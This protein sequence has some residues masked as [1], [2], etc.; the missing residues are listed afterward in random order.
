MQALKTFTKSKVVLHTFIQLNLPRLFSSKMDGSCSQQDVNAKPKQSQQLELVENQLLKQHCK[1]VEQPSE[2][3]ANESSTRRQNE[4]SIPIEFKLQIAIEALSQLTNT[5]ETRK[6]AA[7]KLICTLKCMLQEVDLRISD[8]QRSAHDFHKEVVEGGKCTTNTERYKAEKFIRYM[9]QTLLEQESTLDK[10]TLKNNALLTRKQKLESQL[11]REEGT[12]FH[13]IDYHQVRSS[14][15]HVIINC[16]LDYIV[17][18]QHT[19][20]IV[21]SHT[22]A[23]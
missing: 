23:N 6:E 2:A 19:L 22:D 7:N 11:N 8:I 21:W 16:Q 5:L 10:L 3:A 14:I 15:R 9:E 1:N 12:S 13:F 17:R 4:S 20:Y 18:N